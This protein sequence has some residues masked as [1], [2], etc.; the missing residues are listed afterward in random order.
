MSRQS[1]IKQSLRL[2]IC[3]CQ[4]VRNQD[5]YSL[6][7]AENQPRRCAWAACDLMLPVLLI[8]LQ[9][10]H[11]RDIIK[12]GL[13]EVTHLCCCRPLKSPGCKGDGRTYGA[14]LSP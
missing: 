2:G 12:G 9:I 7:N 4:L 3:V 6:M 13:L 8:N 11:A 10:A 14:V 1:R 5:C